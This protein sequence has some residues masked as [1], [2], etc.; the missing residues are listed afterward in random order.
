L[1]YYI[2]WKNFFFVEPRGF[3]APKGNA[4]KAR[5]SRPEKTTMENVVPF[6]GK[7]F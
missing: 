7:L 6:F 3:S 4:L 2:F 5:P 1:K